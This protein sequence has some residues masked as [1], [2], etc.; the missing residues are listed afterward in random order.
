[1]RLMNSSPISTWDFFTKIM[2]ST[3]VLLAF[4]CSSFTL[5]WSCFTY[6]IA[7]PS[8]VALSP[9]KK[10]SNQSAIEPRLNRRTRSHRRRQ[11][12]TFFRFGMLAERAMNCLF[13]CS[14]RFLSASIWCGTGKPLRPLPEL[15]AALIGCSGAAALALYSDEG[16]WLIKADRSSNPSEPCCEGSCP[17]GMKLLKS[18]GGWRVEVVTV[19]IPEVGRQG[20]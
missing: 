2:D 12:I 13:K 9:W 15:E 6:L 17:N 7:S 18:I 8:T 11:G 4:S 1:M 5:S 10:T 16:C 19:V 20:I 14:L 3:N